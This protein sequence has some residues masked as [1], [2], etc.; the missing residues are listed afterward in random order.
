MERLAQSLSPYWRVGAAWLFLSAN[1]DSEKNREIMR[2]RLDP[3]DVV[4]VDKPDMSDDGGIRS[5][6]RCHSREEDRLFA[7]CIAYR[8]AFHIDPY[9][10]MAICLYI[11]DPSLRYELRKGSFEKGWEQ[12]IPNIADRIIGGREF[13]ENCGAC[14]LRKD[15]RWCPVY[16]YLEHRR[17]SARVE[18]LCA[19]AR[20]SRR[21]KDNWKKNH[22]RYYQIAGVTVQV[23]SDL[24]ITDT[25]FHP[26]FKHFEVDGPGEDNIII[27]HHFDLPD[28]KGRNLG[29][30][31]YRKPPWAIYK[32]L[33]SWLYL[34]FS[35][36]PA[37]K[38]YHSVAVINDD[39]TRTRIFTKNISE[40]IYSKGN[41]NSLTLFPSDQI[42][43]A[44]LLADRQG[45]Y[46]HSS[47]VILG[48]KGLLFM[49]HSGAGKSTI[50][51]VF[52]GKAEI[53]CDDRIIVRKQPEGFKIYGTWSHGEV[54]D[55]SAGAALLRAILFLEKGSENRIV[56]LDDKKVAIRKLLGCLIKPLV[57]A[58]WWEKMLS[59]MESIVRGV[60]CYTLYF[61]K[62]GMVVDLLRFHLES[63][64]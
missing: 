59:L 58:D 5:S 53:L 8:Q 60:P 6:T 43:L 63:Q 10:H 57:T 28:L 45:C 51:K 42:L 7:S 19:V 16:G 29:K 40:K 14:D 24:P 22:R 52:K 54:P 4:A 31:I 55:V 50:V 20:Q 27:K 23:D 32:N 47:G 56:P 44:R 49:G 30:E 11:K 38:N 34:G 18:Y 36:P 1:G 17:F 2:Q 48:G 37:E 62:S 46:F 21:F 3:E 39:H 13:M 25:T 12:F 35:S 26:K 41:L 9:G 33:G 64:D 61:D 15:C